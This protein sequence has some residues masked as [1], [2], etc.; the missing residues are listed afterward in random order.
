MKEKIINIFKPVFKICIVFS[1]IAVIIAIV[2]A[3]LLNAAIL[4]SN[5][6]LDFSSIFNPVHI[7]STSESNTFVRNQLYI[8]SLTSLYASIILSAIGFI[9]TIIIAILENCKSK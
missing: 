9:G 6:Y 1:L 5:G 7:L 3:I 4:A 8:P 2:Y